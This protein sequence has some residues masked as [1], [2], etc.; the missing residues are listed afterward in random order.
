MFVVPCIDALPQDA[1]SN[2]IH[3]LNGVEEVRNFSLRLT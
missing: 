3:T 1:C 2:N